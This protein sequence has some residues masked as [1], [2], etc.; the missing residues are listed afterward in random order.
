[1]LY[2]RKDLLGGQ[3]SGWEEIIRQSSA[4]ADENGLLPITFQDQEECGKDMLCILFELINYKKGNIEDGLKLYKSILQLS[5]KTLNSKEVSNHSA[6]FKLGEALIA[7]G[8]GSQHPYLN[9]G[10]SLVKRSFGASPLPAIDGKSSAILTGN[11]LS[12]SKHSQNLDEAADFLKFFSGNNIYMLFAK[13]KM[14]FPVTKSL[15]SSPVMLDACPFILEYRDV[16]E[17]MKTRRAAEN[18]MQMSSKVQEAVLLYLDNGI[19]EH[20]AA[21]EIEKIY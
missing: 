21:K 13:E 19:T 12:I 7:R 20:E 17:S 1:M 11:G 16:I 2:Y 8:W 15:Y 10:L 5:N 3:F 6:S 18:Y 9:D 4:I 14:I